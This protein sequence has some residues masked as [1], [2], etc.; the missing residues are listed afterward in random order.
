MIDPQI[1]NLLMISCAAL[2]VTGAV[3]CLHLMRKARNESQNCIA[4][5]TQLET[6]LLETSRD[7]D[8]VSQRATDQAR[9]IAWL[10]SRVRNNLTPSLPVDE[11]IPARTP[12]NKPTITER[13]HRV[14]Q[15][16]RRGVDCHTI[17]SMLNMPQGEVELMISLNQLN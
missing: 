13:R 12:S 5:A 4:V 7:L 8:T 10:E 14:N 6:E 1:F 15:L 16:S 17:A 3:T 11:E 9:R 2:M